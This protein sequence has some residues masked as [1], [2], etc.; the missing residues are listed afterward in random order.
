MLYGERSV[1][2]VDDNEA[3][4]DLIAR[5]LEKAG[6][7]VTSAVNGAEALKLLALER[8]DL[9]LLDVMMPEMD[10]YTVLE[11]IKSNPILRDIPVIMI[12]ALNE[13]DSVTRCIKL[14][15]E[16]YIIKPLDMAVVQSRIW[17]CLA[18]ASLKSKQRDPARSRDGVRGASVLVID[19]LDVNRDMLAARLMRAGYE[20]RTAGGADEAWKIIRET[21]FDLILL[22]LH[23]PGVNGFEFLQAIKQD[24]VYRKVPVIVLTADDESASMERALALG[25]ADYMLKPFNAP[26]LKSRIDACIADVRISLEC[27]GGA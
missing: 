20:T 8:Y 7:L 21:P 2:V 3:N 19:D 12:T 10:G 25:A 27:D 24:I 15:A 9:V 26:L 22:D 18:K 17:R 11:R 16:D 23:M 1:L 14:G 6:Y 4:R 5:R 13:A